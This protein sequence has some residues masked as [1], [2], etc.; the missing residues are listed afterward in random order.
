VRED[1]VGLETTNGAVQ[2]QQPAYLAS[3]RCGK[4]QRT[5]FA[6]NSALICSKSLCS[7]IS[8]VMQRHDRLADANGHAFCKHLGTGQSGARMT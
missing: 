5:L 4:K 2:E 6:R 8:E 1:D 3:A 7:G